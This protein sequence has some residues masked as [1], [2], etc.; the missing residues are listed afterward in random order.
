MAVEYLREVGPSLAEQGYH[1]L[2]LAP[3]KKYPLIEDW[4][5]VEAT[6]KEVRKWANNG[7]R[8][9]GVGILCGNVIGVDID[10]LDKEISKKVIKWCV[11]NLGR[12]PQR[13]GLAPKTLFVF[14]TETPFSKIT[15]NT[16]SDF[17]E[18]VHK[19]E[20]LG[21]G[22]QFVAYAKHP[23]TGK[24]YKWMNGPGISDIPFE[25]LPIITREQASKL[26]EYFES[27]A[28][29]EWELKSGGHSGKTVGKAQGSFSYNS[30]EHCKPK[31]D[32]TTEQI[33]K[34]LKEI[35][36][37]AD[38]PG[39]YTNWS[40]VGMALWH[41]YDGND[42]GFELW[43]N[44]S[45]GG[46]EYETCKK[47]MRSKWRSF[48]PTSPNFVTFATVLG[49]RNDHIAKIKRSETV[50]KLLEPGETANSKD[51]EP[52]EL[53]DL[54]VFLKRYILVEQ[55]KQ[56]CDLTRDAECCLSKLDE[57]QAATANVRHEVPAP[58]QAE[59]EKTKLAPVAN[60]WLVN[61]DRKTAFAAEFDPREPRVFVKEGNG[62]SYINTYHVP[63]FSK[64][65]A[66]KGDT[67]IFHAHMNYLTPDESEREWFINWLAFNIQRPEPRCKVTPLHVS[68]A[69]G[70]GRGWVVELLRKLVGEWN[71]STTKMEDLVGAA[72]T[73]AYNEYLDKSLICTI[74]EVKESSKRYE[75]SNKIRSVLSDLKYNVNIKFGGKKSQAIFT[76]FFL[77]SNHVDALAL[78]ANDRRIQVLSGPKEPQDN[79]YYNRLYGWAAVKS[80]V[81]ALYFELLER[82]I[83]AFDWQH[84]SDTP[85]RARMVDSTRTPTET[86]FLD[87]LR[88]AGKAAV[89]YANVSDQVQNFMEGDAFDE[90][91]DTRQILKLL[92]HHCTHSQPIKF[93][94]KSVR[95]W[96][97]G[98][99]PDVDNKLIREC[100]K[101]NEKGL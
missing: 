14:R 68:V 63:E 59:P 17:F 64:T 70:T 77:M 95:P 43:D 30:M 85:G 1:V 12:A 29:S 46:Y 22:Q 38:E 34:I 40:N 4:S 57:F 8:A 97:L 45:S 21:K 47:E 6:A 52:E 81:A 90:A 35:R 92:Q 96:L 32:K 83:S 54:D 55:G 2:P 101:E 86:A 74:E 80:N 66:S 73:G 84:S 75:V 31:A 67:G 91:V 18:D 99:W 71:C 53:D 27:I 79:E 76:N 87:Y 16:Y 20:I 33:E 13:V 25:E 9:S 19:V 44:W 11:E 28:P 62:L 100:L 60:S 94:G 65:T 56:V 78:P 48:R 49:V 88:A 58:T 39:Q 10:I 3:G 5:N 69:H 41:Q 82:D 36:H 72:S 89:L 15:S 7:Y 42:E 51:A 37:V 61:E 23:D 93:E 98:E 24:S 50:S 26:V